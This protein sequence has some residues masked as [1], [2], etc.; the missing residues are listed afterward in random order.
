MGDRHNSSQLRPQRG[1]CTSTTTGRQIQRVRLSQTRV[2]PEGTV[3]GQI[4]GDRVEIRSRSLH[5]GMAFNYVFTGVVT[6]DHGS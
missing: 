6:G 1:K 5:E 3:N 4:S 2:V